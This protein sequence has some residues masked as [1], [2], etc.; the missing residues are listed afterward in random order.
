M[1]MYAPDIL[2]DL[3]VCV[4]RAVVP[5]PHNIL[6]GALVGRFVVVDG[7]SGC[8]AEGGGPRGMTLSERYLARLRQLK[9]SAAY[10]KSSGDVI[11]DIVNTV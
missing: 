10:S 2:H 5:R 1:Q 4:R 8:G 7:Q 9:M 6:S 11:L 3:G